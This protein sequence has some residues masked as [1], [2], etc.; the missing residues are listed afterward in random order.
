MTPVAIS[1]GLVAGRQFSADNSSLA[2]G[3]ALSS[4]IDVWPLN[5]GY[6]VRQRGVLEKHAVR[7]LEQPG[8][9]DSALP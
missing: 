2:T 9:S 8:L 5:A 6:R 1:H 4:L 7:N 3:G